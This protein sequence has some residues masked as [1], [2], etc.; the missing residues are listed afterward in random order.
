MTVPSSSRILALLSYVLVFAGA[1]FVLLFNRKDEFAAFHARQALVLFLIA[2][3]G[4][5]V[6]LI[7]GW[8]LLWIPNVGAVTVSALFALVISLLLAVLYAWVSGLINALRAQR[9]PVP[10]FGD[11]VHYL[12]L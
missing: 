4:P 12:P 9:K 5:L 2:L 7:V 10:L 8:V 6:W 1:L 11:W 3:L